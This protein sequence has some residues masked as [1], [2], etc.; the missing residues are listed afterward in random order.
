MRI[1]SEWAANT[2]SWWMLLPVL[3]LLAGHRGGAPPVPD[4]SASIRPPIETRWD[5]PPEWVAP[6]AD[7]PPLTAY[8]TF[9]SR[10]IN[11]QVSYLVYLP[12]DYEAHPERRY[13]VVYWLHGLGCGPATGAV[14]VWRLD[15]AIKA[16]RAPAMIA[17]LVNGLR[18]SMYC[19][20]ADGRTPV[21]S[22]IITDLIPHVD[23][24]Y[25]TVPRREGRALARVYHADFENTFPIMT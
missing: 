6:R 3:P 24:T 4:P 15:E 16:G 18:A 1:T 14:F 21:E 22:V 19:D 5:P 7:C 11:G 9:H 10:T 20:S 13:P 2:R 8:R 17:I 12:P 23:G 25:R